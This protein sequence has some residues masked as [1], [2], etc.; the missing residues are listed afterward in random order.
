MTFIQI[1][2]LTFVVLFRLWVITVS[3]IGLK[4]DH[5]TIKVADHDLTLIALYGIG[6]GILYLF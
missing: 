5:N 2:V 4:G 6:K 3:I 1:L